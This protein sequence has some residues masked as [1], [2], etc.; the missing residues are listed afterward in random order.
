MIPTI[1]IAHNYFN[2]SISSDDEDPDNIIPSIS[3]NYYNALELKYLLSISSTTCT[4]SSSYYNNSFS[5]F[6]CNIRSLQKHF[7]QFSILISLENQFSIIGISETRLNYN[8]TSNI[9]LPNYNFLRHD[10]P[11]QVCGVGL[12]VHNSLIYQA[13]KNEKFKP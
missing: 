6:H 10:S 7:N 5:I 1:N 2:D 13:P 12:Y 11:T 9:D 3:S 8:S 4:D